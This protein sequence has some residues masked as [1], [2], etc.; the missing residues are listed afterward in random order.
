MISSRLET[1]LQKAIEL[2]K[3]NRHE[4]ATLE[5]LLIAL[6]EDE[7]ALE[8]FK[9]TS[10]NPS[11]VRQELMDYLD[12]QDLVL[13]G[14]APIETRVTI[15]FQRVLQRASLQADNEEINAIHLL[16]SLFSENESYAV[17]V[18]EN[19]QITRVDL[20]NY[21]SEMAKRAP[22][23]RKET[24]PPSYQKD[25]HT[26]VTT[27]D[28]EPSM[29]EKFCT[30]LNKMALNGEIE[31]LIGREEPIQR[32]IH[33]LCRKE[34]N[35]PLLLGDSGVGKTALI[36]G[37]ALKIAQGDVPP[38]LQNAKVFALDMAGLVAG[39]RFRGDFEERFKGILKGLEE[40][41][42]AILFIDEAHIMV[43]TGSVQGGSMD[44]SNM[45]KPVLLHGKIRCIAATTFKEY[46]THLEKDTGLLRR[47]Q[48]VEISEPS[49]TESIE[50]LDG[51]KE[52]LETYH[53][54]KYK[55]DTIQAA[56]ELSVRHLMDRRL[57]DKA[58]DI[59]DEAG[60]KKRLEAETSN[61]TLTI[62]CK[63]VEDVVAQ[64]AAI[65]PKQVSQDD[66]KVLKNL[67]K[68]L[69]SV[70]FGQDNAASALVHSIK[71]SR[72]GLRSP[73]KPIGCYLFSG[74]TGVGKTEICKQLSSTLGMPLI[75]F[76]MSEYME[77]HS[78]SKLIGAP[79]GYVGFEQGGALT[80][81]VSKTP[82]CIIL[83][84][85]IEKAHADIYNVLLQLM[86]YGIVTDHH[87]NSVNY[88]N[89]ILI[90]TTNAGATE[91]S[92]HGLGFGNEKRSGED[93]TAIQRIFSP[94]FRNRLDAIIPFAPLT[95][96]IMEKIVDKFL[97]ELKKQLTER[98]IDL[99]ISKEGKL[100]L[101][102]HGFDP[103]YGA[104]PLARTIDEHVKKPL[105]DQILFG[106]L[107][108]GGTVEVAVKDDQ[109]VLEY[110][111]VC[112]ETK[113]KDNGVAVGGVT[114]AQASYKKK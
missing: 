94:E 23:F 57:P 15:G 50:I 48:K 1:T 55:E 7:D 78:I 71:L 18:M 4:Y 83:L 70:V 54:V 13:P 85:E 65:P 28:G 66:K 49:V 80:D 3:H 105:A 52:S 108:K 92:K 88:R 102:D 101:R 9:S 16:I 113:K 110:F 59:L 60:A 74:P 82:H 5:H 109:L 8:A 47:F 112:A 30:N 58:I 103:L 99:E 72:S 98:D 33:I 64:M 29:V 6:M 31:P 10:A 93:E 37:L 62:T 75:R 106:K 45:L 27:E 36:E 73:E 40:E 21:L 56:V 43:G 91:L 89:V 17:H 86:D 104:R 100:W 11:K 107:Q 63:D 46:K 111:K 51:L 67:E 76:D 26:D 38:T 90:M 25:S 96:E 95:S 79:P 14:S 19:Q 41:E 61:K 35:N 97:K 84:D 77:K 53:N 12:A 42:K 44:T 69:Q 68:D 39:T 2:A 22:K 81:A 34:K 87:G 20:L 24:P 32:I 114:K